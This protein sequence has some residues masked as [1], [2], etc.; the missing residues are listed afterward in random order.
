MV[1]FA[2][3]EITHRR[4]LK[5]AIPILLSNATVPILG[6]VDT[7][8]IGQLGEAA[9]IGAVGLGSI[10]ITTIYGLFGFLRMGTSGLASQ[11]KG[12]GDDYELS[13]IIFRSLMIG[14]VLGVLVLILH[15][16]LFYLVMKIVPASPEVEGLTE[17]YVSIRI[18]SAPAA[19]ATYGITGWLIAQERTQSVLVLQLAMNGLN[20]ILDILFV[21]GLN[22]GVEGVAYATLIAEWFALFLGLYL[23]REALWIKFWA[24]IHR[25][26]D[27]AKFNRMVSVNSDI[28]IRSLFLGLALV[29]FLFLSS[30]FGDI[31]LAANQI[32]LQFLFFTAYALDG[33]AFSSETLVG[34]S[35]GAENKPA[36][37][38]SSI[39]TSAWGMITAVIVSVVFALTGPMIITIMTTEPMVRIEA[40]NYLWWVVLV[41]IIGG[42][43]WFLDGIFIGATKTREMRN[44]MMISFFFYVIALV[45]TMPTMG[46]AG[47]WLS[48]YIL[49]I[50]RALTLGLKYPNLERMD[51]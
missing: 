6:A 15:F 18:F 13:M 24:E 21:L 37:R 9:P 38:K 20:V 34:Q 8:V 25:I 19:I 11:E 49:F 31:T 35:I 36:V 5:I 26:F 29:S 28:L 45:I 27:R 50:L 16:Q 43:S 40:M 32:L 51:S 48:L 44:G 3:D 33:F 23:C 10:I 1:N 30:D 39:L 2:A 4:I 12:K 42:P 17:E 41:P 7:G 22:Y 46:N 14:F 47:L